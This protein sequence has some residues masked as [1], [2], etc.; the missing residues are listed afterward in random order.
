MNIVR[1][2][3]GLVDSNYT[4]CMK[5]HKAGKKFHI[6]DGFAEKDSA[7]PSSADSDWFPCCFDD[8]LLGGTA[9]IV[10]WPGESL[11]AG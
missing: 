5:I 2:G 10:L 11:P 6:S 3:S 1:L 4:T 8:F 7:I 9:D